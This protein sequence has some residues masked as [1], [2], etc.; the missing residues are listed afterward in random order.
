MTRPT[1]LHAGLMGACLALSIFTPPL[2]AGPVADT[3]RDME[4]ASHVYTPRAGGVVRTVGPDAACNYSDLQNALS[5][6]SDDDTVRVMSGT[7]TGSFAVYSKSLSVIGG[8]PDCTSTTPS[9]RSTLDGQGNGLVLDIY[10]PADSGDPTRQVNIENMII[11]NGGGSGFSSGGALVQGRPGLFTVN[12]RNVEISNNSRD[13]AADDGAGL[14]VLSFGDFVGF[15]T[16]VT[17]DNDSVIA[18]NTTAG[19]GGGVH[20]K[21]SY[22]DGTVTMLRMGTTPVIGNE[23]ENG[24]GIAVDGCQNVFLYN[25]GPVFLF[26]PAGGFVNNTAV[27]GGGAIYIVNGGE[28]FLRGISVSGFGD[29]DEAALLAN[30]NAEYGGAARVRGEGSS[31]EVED[32]YVIGNT[33]GVLGGAFRV[34]LGASLTVNRRNGADEC[35]PPVSSGGVLSRPRCSVIDD[36]TGVTG[37]GAF[38]LA[39]ESSIDVGRTIVRN[40]TAGGGG[41]PVARVT[42]SSI[43]TG[44]V[45]AFRME[46]SLVYGNDG[47]FLFSANNN[48]RIRIF[49]STVV[50]NSTTFARLVAQDPNQVADIEVFTSIVQTSSWLSAVGDGTLDLRFDC[51]IGNAPSGDTGATTSFAYSNVDPQFV[52][53]AEN[54]YRLGARSPAID[55][56]DDVNPPQFDDLDG[57]TR[58]VAWSGPDPDS[59]PNA[60]SGA[61]DLGAFEIPFDIQNV[62]LAVEP[63]APAAFVGGSGSFTLQLEVVNQGSNTAFA[64]ISVIDDF[65]SGAVVNQQWTC[66]APSGVTCTPSSGSGD[67]TTTVS[68]L[69]AGQSVTFEVT[70][71]PAS[72][73]TDDEF[74]YV[75]IATES[76]FNVDTSPSNNEATVEIRT[77]I[78]ADG[79]E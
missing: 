64:D 62:D 18:Q 66:S 74:S 28:V 68:D 51:V 40:N 52:D 32:A 73:G 42:N 43:Y 36:N 60:A 2:Q 17:V 1:L 6:S 9:G 56:C 20:C 38:S 75:M 57:N 76:A 12:F 45:S 53:A 35:E 22:D 16:F 59:A 71:T 72:P 21:S 11:R 41:G 50:D 77:G 69:E 47:I 33:A 30:N 13:G 55:Y 23:A 37:G 67:I 61:F 14:R 34:E 54:N 58:G 78:F 65:T 7:Y 79:F 19:D 26:I 27:D 31:L 25:G 4:A 44:A 48:A 10:Y 49:H 39:G 3:D 5:A 63:T 15:G 46:G 8:F 24:G 29:T 70:A